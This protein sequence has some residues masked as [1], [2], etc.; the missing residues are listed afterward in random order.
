MIPLER[1]K[2]AIP[3][4]EALLGADFHQRFT[5]RLNDAL[6]ASGLDPEELQKSLDVYDDG[7]GPLPPLPESYY[8]KLEEMA[9]ELCL[10][11]HYEIP[12]HRGGLIGGLMAKIKWVFL[13]IKLRTDV[14]VSQQ[15]KFNIAALLNLEILAA[16]N[17]HL[18]A[19]L[20]WLTEEMQRRDAE[21]AEEIA[22]LRDELKNIR[23]E[24]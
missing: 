12:S 5:Q 10:H 21:R 23:G 19:S 13:Q 7:G 9:D 18:C 14:Q 17:E 20:D 11:S 3:A 1:L 2:K 24:Q 4:N 22:T 16:Q 6:Q 15:A 8:Q